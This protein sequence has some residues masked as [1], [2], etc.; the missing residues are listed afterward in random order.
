M[1]VLIGWAP[2]AVE[3]VDFCTG[4]ASIQA[5]GRDDMTIGRATDV[6]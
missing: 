3:A 4:L 1:G 5:N 2:A 6:P